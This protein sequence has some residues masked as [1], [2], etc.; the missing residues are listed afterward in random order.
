MIHLSRLEED[1]SRRN[2]F[3]GVVEFVACS[4]GAQVLYM[5]GVRSAI[6]LRTSSLS[7]ENIAQ[8][9]N[10]PS[11]VTSHVHDAS[12]PTCMMRHVPRA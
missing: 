11:C 10:R 4:D 1:I 3:H 7:F 9:L 2:R 8:N 12:R 5:D 6:L